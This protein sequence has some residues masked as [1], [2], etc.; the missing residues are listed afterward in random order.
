[1]SVDWERVTAFA[2]LGAALALGVGI[3]L[4]L[5]YLVRG[6]LRWV[7][8]ER[9]QNPG[10]K[11]ADRLPKAAETGPSGPFVTASDLYAIRANLDVAMRQIESLEKRLKVAPAPRP[12]ETERPSHR[13][14]AT[15]AEA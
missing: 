13:P 11:R 9:S 8:G 2:V 6:V 4:G 1:M 12:R 15:A 5:I 7:F 3:V 10:R 14:Q